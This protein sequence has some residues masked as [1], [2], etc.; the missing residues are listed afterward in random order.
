MYDTSRKCS[1]MKSIFIFWS[2]R[3]FLAFASHW[4]AKEMAEER[5]WLTHVWRILQRSRSWTSRTARSRTRA[6]PPS[7]SAAWWSVPPTPTHPLSSRSNFQYMGCGSVPDPDPHVF[8]PTRSGSFYYQAIL[9]RETLIPSVLWL[10][11]DF[12]SLNNYVNVTS[13]G[14]KQKNL[15]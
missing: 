10:L 11:F 15:F 5:H 7:P 6:P 12:L 14:K 1:Q 8:G 9:V 4:P 13:K 2:L 3:L